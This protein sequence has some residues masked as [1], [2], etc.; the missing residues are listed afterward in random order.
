MDRHELLGVTAR[1]LFVGLGWSGAT[2]IGYGLIASATAEP[3][4][5]VERIALPLSSGLTI[6]GAVVTAALIYIPL[7]EEHPPDLF[8]RALT[9]P[10]TILGG[11]VALAVLLSTGTLPP[12]LVNG[13]ALLGLAGG[14][15]RIQRRPA[16]W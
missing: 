1:G 9:A 2:F 4:P 5:V 8:S 14:L 10:A 16:S 11:V 6:V 13:F 12:V 3:W 15:L 7:S